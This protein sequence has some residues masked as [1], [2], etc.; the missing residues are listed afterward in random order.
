MEIRVDEYGNVVSHK[1]NTLRPY[2]TRGGYLRVTCCTN[3]K[4][5]KHLVH[6]LVA[7][8]FLSDYS[9]SLTVN[10]INGIKTDNRV[11]NLEMCTGVENLKHAHRT[12][13]IVVDNKGIKNGM[14]KL[15]QLQVDIIKELLYTGKTCIEIGLMYGVSRTTISDIKGGRTWRT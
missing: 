11:G 9:E 12:G 15:T 1:G 14:S 7:K 4:A 8:T 6:R 3:G 13:L 5:S 2:I 10:H